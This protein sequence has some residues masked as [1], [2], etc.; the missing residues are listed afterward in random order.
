MDK[1]TEIGDNLKNFKISYKTIVSIS[2]IIS[3]GIFV[4]L[5]IFPYDIPFKLDSLDYFSYAFTTSQIGELPKSWA[6]AN[7]GWPVI[8]SFFFRL[9]DGEFLDYVFLQRFLSIIFSVL[10]V[11]PLFFIAKQFVP[12]NVAILST[13]IFIFE[14]RIILNSLNGETIPIYI[15]VGVTIVSLFLRNKIRYTYI[16]FMLIA[17]LAFIRYEGILLIIPLS[18]M[19]FFKYRNKKE[20]IRYIIII[21][22]FLLVLV[23][24]VYLRIDAYGQD[25]ISSHLI[26]GGQYVSIKLIEGYS[27]DEPWI[28]EEKNNIAEFFYSGISGVIKSFGFSLIPIF[29]FFIVP[30][31]IL[32]LKEKNFFRID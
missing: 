20:I 23:P 26:S 29:G 2:L 19:F 5:I 6:L 24:I 11:I 22:L 10:T 13:I 17:I 30:S 14:P 32:C 12:K 9:F 1:T 28:S 3:F 4:R 15:F 21:G 8:V 31:L 27:D 18:V 16:A 7:N 25:G